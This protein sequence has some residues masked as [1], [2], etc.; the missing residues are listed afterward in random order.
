[1]LAAWRM[2]ARGIPGPCVV[3]LPHETFEGYAEG[4]DSDG[5]LRLRLDDGT[6]RRIVAGDV[7]FGRG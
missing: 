3:R 7:F 6:S 4:L 2:R 1:M 5:A